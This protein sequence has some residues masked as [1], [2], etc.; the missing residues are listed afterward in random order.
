MLIWRNEVR[1]PLKP[2]F[3]EIYVDCWTYFCSKLLLYTILY[4]FE[5]QKIACTP[6]VKVTVVYF[7]NSACDT[8]TSSIICY[9]VENCQAAICSGQFKIHFNQNY[10]NTC[11]LWHVDNDFSIKIIYQNIA[12]S[13][14]LFSKNFSSWKFFEGRK[15]FRIH[16]RKLYVKLGFCLKIKREIKIR[17]LF[18]WHKRYS[19]CWIYF[20]SKL[21]LNTTYATCEI[22]LLFIFKIILNS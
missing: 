9:F 21:L 19:G 17:T 20:W 11:N 3:M 12:D 16:N 2:F 14:F 4:H 6:F 5:Y 18:F 7:S 10:P 22:L 13:F 15:W 1:Y 8:N